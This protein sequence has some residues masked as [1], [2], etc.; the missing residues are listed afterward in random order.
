M[1]KQN[2]IAFLFDLDGVLIDSE[3]EYTK[4]WGEINEAYPT[5]IPDFPIVIKG[6]TLPEILF[7][8]FPEELHAEV[9]EMLNA[10]EQ[11]MRY[12]MLPG[13]DSVL[14]KLKAEGIKQAL[15]TSSN[16]LKM[17]HLEEELPGFT[18]GF[19]A[20]VTA[21][22]VKHSKPHPEPYL[23]GASLLGMDPENCI[24]IEDSAQGVQAGN[25]AG[26][27]V[28]GLTTTLPESAISRWCDIVL[29]D[30][31]ELDVKQI[32]DHIVERRGK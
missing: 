23:K 12:R 8:Y 7:T 21:E 29:H 16:G 14:K 19:N 20:L 27:F 2:N 31:S 17:L 22:D 28:I 11:A 30:L 15:V 13:A 1:K 24:V 25:A 10:K 4:I 6:R 32:I 3:K 9:T 18:T 5:G 26:C